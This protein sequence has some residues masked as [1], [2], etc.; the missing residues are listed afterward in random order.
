[1]R[2]SDISVILL[3]GLLSLATLLAVISN[4]RWLIEKV[5]SKPKTREVA[6]T[7][8]MAMKQMI[9]YDPT[10]V[11]VDLL[12]SHPHVLSQIKIEKILADCSPFD[13]EVFNKKRGASFIWYWIVELI[14]N[15]SLVNNNQFAYLV[16]RFDPSKKEQI[17]DLQAWFF[18]TP[19]EA[20]E[21]AITSLKTGQGQTEPNQGLYD[22][23]NDQLDQGRKRRSYPDHKFLNLPDSK[24]IN[25]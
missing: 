2:L 7:M 3:V 16:G 17:S 4:L 20:L 1:V 10:P 19:E 11:L 12:E 25:E 13:K 8:D 6:K 5:F 21:C 15:H 24:N 22:F 9:T 23:L 14:Q 18:P